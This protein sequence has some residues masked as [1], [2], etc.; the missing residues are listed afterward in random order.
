MTYVRPKHD[1]GPL[2]KGEKAALPALTILPSSIHRSG[3]K[4]SGSLKYR[5][6]RWRARLATPISV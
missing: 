2:E 1:L 4:L 3:T 5:G 6:L